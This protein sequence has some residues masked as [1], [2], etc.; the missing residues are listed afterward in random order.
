[1]SPLKTRRT[2]GRDE[3]PE[4]PGFA[5]INSRIA[6][7]PMTPNWAVEAAMKR[8]NSRL[9]AANTEDMRLLDSGNF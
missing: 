4:T 9:T 2:S 1:V 3:T 8:N 6:V 5:Q 7:D